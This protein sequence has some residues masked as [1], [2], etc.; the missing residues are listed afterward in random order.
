M[1]NCLKSLIPGLV[2]LTAPGYGD[3]YPNQP[4]FPYDALGK[5]SPMFSSAD[6][7]ASHWIALLDQGQY[8]A[9][10]AD[11]GPLFQDVIAQ[12]QWVAAMKAIRR[13]LGNVKARSSGR[14]RS[15]ET[16]PGGTKG[17]FFILE[18]QTSFS[19]KSSA[20]ETL[21]LMMIQNDQWRVISYSVR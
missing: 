20:T 17:Y 1:K 12:D 14:H 16:L 13:P 11:A 3:S 5:T 21:I 7:E 4:P 8:G 10:W 2:L 15:T 9:A 18:Y 6:S 19:G